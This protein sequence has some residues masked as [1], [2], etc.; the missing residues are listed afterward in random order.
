MRRKYF[1]VIT[2]CLVF[3]SAVTAQKVGLV[4]SGGGAR[5]AAHI[6]VIKALEE[7]NVPIDYIAGTSIGAIVGSLYAMGYTPDEMLELMLSE[8]FGNWQT[9]TVKKEYI[10]YFKKPEDTPQFM[11]FSLN[12]KDSLVF[13]SLLPGSIV[14]PV[15]MNQAFLELYAQATAKA[16]WNFDNLFVPF[17]C[18]GADI[19]GKKPI[20]FR[21]GDL[22]D[23]V[24][25]SMTFP[26]I[27]KPI[28]KDGVPLFDGGIYNN[29]PIDVM[30]ADFDPDFI[31]GSAVRG[32][33]WRPSENP[34]NQV[35]PMVMQKTDY[36]VPEDEGMLIEMRLPDVSLLDFYK[37]KEVMQIGY[38]RAMSVIHSIK[39]RVSRE[40]PLEEVTARRKDYKDS[41]PP[42]IFNNIYVTGV[43]EEQQKYVI[44]QL[45]RDMNEQFTMEEFRR[46]Y[47]K[48]LTY[49]KITEIIPSARY[50]WKNQSFDLYL[51]VKINDD[52]KVSIG[53]NISSHQANQLFLGL[54][55]HS[56]GVTSVDYNANFQMGN[57]FSGIS[58]DGRLFPSARIPGYIGVKLA[59]WNKN[60][61]Q[62]QSLF[63]EDLVPAFIK[64]REGF[65]R[66]R[67]GYP[68]FGQSKAEVFTGLGT[69][70]DL[71][72]Q[73]TVFTG[74]NFDISKYNLFNAGFRFERKTLNY[75]QYPTEGHYQYVIAQYIQGDEDYRAGE[76]KRY[77]DVRRHNWFSLKGVWM[78]YP[79]FKRP[80]NLGFMGEAVVSNKQFSSN[81]TATILRAS[82]FKPTP[83]SKISFNEAFNADS[84]LAGGAIPMIKINE[85][86]HLR[87]EA[88]G[89][90][91]LQQIKKEVIDGKTIARYGKYFNSFQYLGE[92]ALVFHL[93]FVS[94]SMY[95]NGYSYPKNN[96]NVGLN[97]GYLLFDSGFF[98]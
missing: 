50:N 65:I 33:G 54:D 23:A 38:D 86:L 59:Y 61:S 16:V 60:Y 29:F 46:A 21:N 58:M 83:H 98:D 5:G 92:A 8:D 84:Y 1:I 11:T 15:Q 66:L 74:L 82:S 26:F 28:W 72:Y 19:Y 71:Y 64:K 75:R 3:L 9:G 13:N 51:A 62:S 7:N 44:S 52:L 35:E 67:Y 77:V 43:T 73:S 32:G 55:F 91:P 79:A 14:N 69:I 41:L 30:K 6:G 47:F 31:I 45:K 27:F 4:L 90:V 48:M 25:V 88:Y 57:S 37:A 97:I 40:V 87:F 49:S 17:R 2:L 42:L 20:I 81:Y 93:P 76:N 63:Y 85:R 96:F 94:V 80:F 78:N 39:D 89:F 36:A 12:L 24:R 34:I 22:G 68:S 70:S 95:A 53:G 10:F 56:L 18:M